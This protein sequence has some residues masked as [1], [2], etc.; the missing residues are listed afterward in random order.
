MPPVDSTSAPLEAYTT[1]DP[2][3]CNLEVVEKAKAVESVAAESRTAAAAKATG[4][5]RRLSWWRAALAALWSLPEALPSPEIKA[6]NRTL[7]V[8]V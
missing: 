8:T 4:T 2:E 6:R 1:P 7:P 5:A 3:Q